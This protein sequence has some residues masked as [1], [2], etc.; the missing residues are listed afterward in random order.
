MDFNEL[1]S[2]IAVKV[3][4]KISV[5]ENHPE[6]QLPPYEEISQKPKLLILSEDHGTA[7]HDLW[8]NQRLSHKFDI[9]CALTNEY[10]CDMQQFDVV[11]M[12][13]LSIKSL[14]KIAEGIADT[15]FTELAI[16][17]VLLGKRIFVPSEEVEVFQYRETAPKLYY[18]MMIQKIELLKNAG[19]CFCS[20]EQLEQVILNHEGPLEKKNSCPIEEKQSDIA[21]EASKKEAISLTKRVITER[22]IHNICEQNTELI[23]VTE[24]TI[25][26]DLARE[27]AEQRGISFA[28][29]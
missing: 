27:Y 20:L 16:K 19:I 12:R 22:D 13:Y 6:I 1:V 9:T 26:T 25:I 11:V 5:M 23:Y 7:C 18:G 8:E 3:A 4:E 15:P 29:R 14:G 2:Q 21:V 17:A 28:I 10:Q 24:K